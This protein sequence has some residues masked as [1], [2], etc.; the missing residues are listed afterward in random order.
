MVQ[1][2]NT[3]P[4]EEPGALSRLQAEVKESEQ[5]FRSTFDQVAVG[6]AHLDL[7]GRWL[8]V[9]Q[10]LCEILRYSRE[11]L[12]Q[13]DVQSITYPEDLEVDLA[14]MIRLTGE[15]DYTCIIEKRYICKDGTPIWVHV[16][17]SQ[18]RD[19]KGTLLYL[20]AVIEDIHERRQ[21][22]EQIK[23]QQNALEVAARQANHERL[24]LLTL[25]EQ[26]PALICL[27]H[28]PEMTIEFVNQQFLQVTGKENSTGKTVAE[29]FPELVKQGFLTLL[30][31]VY[32]TG[33][34]YNAKEVPVQIVKDSGE[35]V[36][37]YLNFVYQPTR[38]I[39]GKVDGILIHA[40][41][42]TEQFHD[43]RTLQENK[44]RMELAQRFGHIG[45]FEW[46]IPENHII[47]TPELETLYGLPP[48]GFEGRYENWTRRVH[49]EDLKKAEENLQA[50]VKSGSPYNVEFRV[51]WPDG[52]LHWLLGKG[53][54]S[55]YDQQGHPR[56]MTGV[57][58]EI[59]DRKEAEQQVVQVNQELQE[60]NGKLENMVEERTDALQQ[61]N[62]E[63]NRSNQELQDFAYVASHDLQEPLRKI[64]AFGNLL[65]EEYG[66][67][68]EDGK[69]YLDRMRNAAGR[70]RV[71][72]EDLLTFSRVTTKALPFS[73][74]DLN[75]IARETVDDLEARIQSTGG[76]VEVSELPKLEADPRQMHQLFQNLIANA[77]KFH[78][79]DELPVVRVEAEIK[80]YGGEEFEGPVCVLTVAD[81]G[82]GFDEK[83]LDRIFTVFQRLHGKSEYEGTGIGLA[84]VRKIV[85]RHGGTITAHS[86]I[87]EGAT[88]IVTL[89]LIH[90]KYNER[91]VLNDK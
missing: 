56:K 46:N 66:D 16:T 24:R 19:E 85:E 23:Q 22:E 40:I 62:L 54:L 44:I 10:R 8:Q 34:P 39:E 11:E 48:G 75:L 13:T 30:E 70:M 82:I 90:Q 50:A 41:E 78:K 9:N 77:L 6:M 68:I 53:E 21:L 87:G 49:P 15:Q 29:K 5:R 76:R 7:N 74:I 79:P 88:F 81:N 27:L 38:N 71:L 80:E 47:W 86:Q 17:V 67:K 55:E 65:E 37:L 20:I 42:V 52:T 28:G 83:Y 84:V 35:L 26:V 25:F 43:R 3:S 31:Q 4:Q 63:L 14:E 18:A 64:Q 72:I 57:N 2:S 33:E 60:L 61:A 59:T 91:E 51:I 58:I 1:I 12:L 32:H 45:T 73:T 36:D 89:P 69:P